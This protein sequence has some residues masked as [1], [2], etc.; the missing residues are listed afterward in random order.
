MAESTLDRWESR[1]VRVG[2]A[3][4]YFVLT[5]TTTLYL[6]LSPHDTGAKLISLAI[7]LL[8]YGWMF[9]WFSAHPEWRSRQDLMA[10]FILGLLVFYGVL[11]IRETWFGAVSFALYVYASEVLRVKWMFVAVAATAVLA[12]VSIFGGIPT[13]PDLIA[14]AIFLVLF[15]TIACTFTFVGTIW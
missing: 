7:V 15:V 5:V 13:G 3:I 1:L 11:G 14:F 9:F 6:L 12:T 4:P 2:H 8:M 10:V